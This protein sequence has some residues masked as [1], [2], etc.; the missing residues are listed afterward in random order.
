MIW[1]VLFTSGPQLVPLGQ[2]MSLGCLSSWL[3]PRGVRL[4]S[5]PPPL[6]WS[7]SLT[8]ILVICWT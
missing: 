8:L 1:R 6:P 3:L 7:L 4:P 2:V 5:L